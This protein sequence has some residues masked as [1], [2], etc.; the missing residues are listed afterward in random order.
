MFFSEALSPSS[1]QTG[2]VWVWAILLLRK[3]NS[4]CSHALFSALLELANFQKPCPRALL[5]LSRV[6]KALL[7]F[8]GKFSLKTWTEL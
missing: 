5:I 6:A 8:L 3:D 2:P 1:T 7:Q 4:D